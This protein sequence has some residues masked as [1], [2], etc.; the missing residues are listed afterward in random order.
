MKT[1]VYYFVVGDIPDDVLRRR[2]YSVAAGEAGGEVW[3]PGVQTISLVFFSNTWK[4]HSFYK[5]VARNRDQGLHTLVLLDIKVKEPSFESLARGKPVY[6]PARWGT[7]RTLPQY[8]PSL[9]NIVMLHC[10]LQE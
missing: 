2:Y 6:E 5:R 4:P 10:G 8:R 1:A 3:C 7:R 9:P